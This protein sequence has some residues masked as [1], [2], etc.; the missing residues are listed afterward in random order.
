MAVTLIL[1]YICSRFNKTLSFVAVKNEDSS[2]NAPYMQEQS[3][4]AIF[5]AMPFACVV[6]KPEQAE[7]FTVI[8]ANPAYLE[9][10]GTRIEDLLH[11]DTRE[12][13]P[14]NPH[15]EEY[16]G[17]EVISEIFCKLFRT[18]EK[19]V[20]EE[21]R[22]DIPIRGTDKFEVKYFTSENIPVKN[23]HGEVAYI[24]H[25]TREVTGQKKMQ[26][27]ERQIQKELHISKQQYRNFIRQNPDG[28]YRLDLQGNF[29]HA[30]QGLADI[31]GVRIEEIIGTNFLP[32]CAPY[33]QGFIVDHF[34]QAVSGKITSFEADFISSTHLKYT[35]KILLMPMLVDGKVIEVHG[36]SKDVTQMRQ[37][38][39]IMVEKSRFLEVNA[40]FVSSLLENE[41]NDEAL[42][43]TFGVIA[44]TVEADRMY[45]FGADKDRESGEIMISQMVEWCSNFAEPQINNPELQN[46]PISKVE[47]IAPLIKNLP[48]TATFSTLK[49]GALKQIFREE[50]IKSMLLLPIFL[51]EQLFGFVGFDD[52]KVERVWKEEEISFLKSLTQNLTNAFEKREALEKVKKREEELYQSEQKFRAL[53]QEGSDLIGILDIDGYYSF[54]SENY[55]SILGFEPCDLIG[56]NAFRFIHCE[57]WE[58]V[59]EQFMQLKLHKQV[60]ISPF[61]FRNKNDEWRWV[62]TTATNLLNDPAV[63]GIVANS[64]DIT[65]IVEQAREIEHINERYQLAATATQDLIYDWDLEKNIVMRFHRSLKELYGYPSE[66]VNSKDFWRKHVHPD[67]L[68]IEKRNLIK[69]LHD[70]KETFIKTS[71][72]FRRADGS[73]AKVVDRGYIIRDF[74]GKAVRLI[75]ATSDISE[76][77]A[78]KEALKIANKRF[79]MAMKATN[80]M[81][82]DWEIA[83]DSVVRSKGYQNIFGYHTNDATSVHSFWLTKVVKEDQQKVRQSLQKALDDHKV[84]KWKCEYRLT[85][86][87]GNIAYV[88]DRGYILRDEKKVAQRVVGAVLDVT[89]SRKLLRRVQKQNRVLKEIAWEQSHV[90]R[91]PLARIKGL[92]HLLEDNCGGMELEE[93][94]FHIKNSTDELDGIIRNIVERTEEIRSKKKD[95]EFV[96]KQ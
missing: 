77:T 20:I 64:R 28:L 51:Q 60:K 26:E 17:H 66:E 80:E 8:D 88:V 61:R 16:Y 89:N 27:R 91:A 95:P 5:E 81:I 93:V 24:L 43:E 4:K 67:D 38:E 85:K 40:A 12:A 23:E 2:L 92:L 15:A 32:L 58:R 7:R 6:L 82:W 45:Y 74:S 35:L 62:Q 94:M 79:K 87:D 72:R 46:M 75:G 71:Y 11:K 33:H 18:G 39:K 57:D 47:E 37:T 50:E 22:Y 48:F 3:W 19:Q 13:F 14:P 96:Q 86:A 10:T 68:P 1:Y 90:V 69:T 53:V 59:K 84:K 25:T 9:L 55:R 42:H 83:S 56:R 30:N 31:V 73:Y 21:F 36:I 44:Q 52:C 63:K 34:E 65:T 76:I 49:E 70:P 41:I 54:V 78:K 29:L